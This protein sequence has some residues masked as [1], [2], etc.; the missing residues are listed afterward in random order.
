M[1]PDLLRK[2]VALEAE[3]HRLLAVHESAASRTITVEDSYKRLAALSI[4]Q[5]ELF[6]E[7]L[8]ALEHGLFRAAHV[9]SWAGFVDFLHDYLGQDSF[10]ALNAARPAWNI[11]AAEDLRDWADYGVIEAGKAAGFYNKSLMKA[12]HG[13]LNKRNE[14]AHP[15]DYYPD[16]NQSLG[17]LS[18]LFQ[19][20][21]TLQKKLS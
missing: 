8:R 21:D 13:L 19:R 5:E 1:I 15:T 6:K 3:A 9:I 14:C 17:Y 11:G 2:V 10:G 4:T 20:I 7:S 16:L 12:L 18:E